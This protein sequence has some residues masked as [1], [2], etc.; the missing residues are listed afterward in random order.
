MRGWKIKSSTSPYSYVAE[1]M[2]FRV[3]SDDGRNFSVINPEGEVIVNDMGTS[4][5]AHRM[6][7]ALIN[8]RTSQPNINPNQKPA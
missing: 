7:E 8:R 6:A 5:E 2:E 3:T 1:K 4:L